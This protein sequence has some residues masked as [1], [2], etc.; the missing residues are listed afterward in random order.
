MS[1]NVYLQSN[2]DKSMKFL[3][4]RKRSI[5]E[6][7]LRVKKWSS[8]MVLGKELIKDRLHLHTQTSAAAREPIQSFLPSLHHPINCHLLA[9]SLEDGG[10]GSLSQLLQ[11]N[12]GLQLAKWGVA[13]EWRTNKQI[14]TLWRK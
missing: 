7:S 1:R 10:V 11:L 6:T 9:V 3:R 14:V 8:M 2:F 12:V 4:K 5:G 13:L